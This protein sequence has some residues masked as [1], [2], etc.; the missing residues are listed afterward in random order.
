MSSL[1]IELPAEVRAEVARR[2]GDGAAAEAA[3]V[4]AAVR[5]RLAACAE[6]DYLEARAAC[7]SRAA[8]ELALSQAPAVP[9]EPGDE[10]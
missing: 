3:W 9:P 2:A 7:G 6:L 5:E 10:W 1:V 8:F 4:A